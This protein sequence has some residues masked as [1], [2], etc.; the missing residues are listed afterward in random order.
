[1][2]SK[3]SRTNNRRRRVHLLYD[4]QC[5][6]SCM[7]LMDRSNFIESRPLHSARPFDCGPEM[8]LWSLVPVPFN[9]VRR[10]GCGVGIKMDD[11]HLAYGIA[12]NRVIPNPLSD[13]AFFTPIAGTLCLWTTRIQLDMTCSWWPLVDGLDSV[14]LG[15]SVFCY[16]LEKGN[17]AI[18]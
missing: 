4:F 5:F 12:H 1:M 9:R 13:V 15:Q 11:S 2:G 7:W 17:T 8:S 16:H 3:W 14:I 6:L 18:S 10:Q